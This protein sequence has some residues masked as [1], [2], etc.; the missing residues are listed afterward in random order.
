MTKKKIFFL[1]GL[2]RESRH[3]DFFR[4][5]F[6]ER[7]P[8]VET[9]GFDLL[10]T[11]TKLSADCPTKISDYVEDLRADFLRE[12]AD[13]NIFLPIS[14]GGMVAFDWLSSYPDDFDHSYI[15]NSSL[16]NYSRFYKR[17]MLRNLPLLAKVG[18]SRTVEYSEKSMLDIVCNNSENRDEVVDHWIEIQKDAPMTTKNKAKQLLAAARFTLNTKSFPRD[19]VTLL[20]G[21]GDRLVSPECSHKIAK[22]LG[23]TLVSHPTAGHALPID[24]PEWLLEQISRSFV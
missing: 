4:G 12:R 15:I 16:G 21:E 11:G 20:V 19:K 18:L 3:Y 8:K 13:V 14:L 10:G 9:Y 17:F 23:L 1:R 5:K 22:G 6:S 24:E 2:V 7:F